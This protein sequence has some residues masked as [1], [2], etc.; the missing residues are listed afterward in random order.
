MCV[1]V[2]S[3][4][5]LPN[6]VLL[7]TQEA[8]V[9]KATVLIY[10]KLPAVGICWDNDDDNLGVPSVPSLQ[11]PIEK[12]KKQFGGQHLLDIEAEMAMSLDDK[13]QRTVRPFLRGF[14]RQRRS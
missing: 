4:R 11:K 14:P 2:T 9:A 1:C 8:A 10:Q 6:H 13:S 3:W 5:F 7:L 12:K